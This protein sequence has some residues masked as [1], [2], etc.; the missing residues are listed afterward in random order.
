MQSHL[1]QSPRDFDPRYSGRLSGLSQ[2]S[3][4]ASP[5]GGMSG[6]RSVP[7]STVRESMLSPTQANASG[8]FGSL[9]QRGTPSHPPQHSDQWYTQPKLLGPTHD[10]PKYDPSHWANDVTYN[11]VR[12]I[13]ADWSRAAQYRPPPLPHPQADA[14]TA[15]GP[16][17]LFSATTESTSE[18]YVQRPLT[19]WQRFVVWIMGESETF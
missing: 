5:P 1:V 3:F 14:A 8:G 9:R 4:Q 13:E 6:H 10:C 2:Q 11:P 19:C 12:V 17:N 15:A 16:T 18:L 7:R